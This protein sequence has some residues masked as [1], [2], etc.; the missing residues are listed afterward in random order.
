MS[1]L[2][3]IQSIPVMTMTLVY[4]ASSIVP[5]NVCNDAAVGSVSLAACI[6]AFL[7]TWQVCVRVC[8]CAG[9]VG[10]SVGVLT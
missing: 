10:G 3:L 8:V 2:Q 7:C 6:K 4:R 1:A 5:D 9:V